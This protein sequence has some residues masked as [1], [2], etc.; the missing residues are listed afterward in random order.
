M[1]IFKDK[2]VAVLGLSVEGLDTMAYFHAKGAR[3]WCCDR[4][5][6]EELGDTYTKLKGIAAGFQ[7]GEN[8][9]AH[10]ER[11]DFIVRTP[12]MSLRLPELAALNKKGKEITSATK[13]FFIEC[14]A[15]IIGVTGT[16]GK[17]TTSTLISEML[18]AGGMHAWLG[19]NVG[20]PLLSK[21][22]AMK[23]TDVVV[24]ELSS[25]QLEDAKESPHIAVVLRT[26]QD[27]LANQDRLAANF[28]E[29]RESYVEAKKSIV[30]YQTD[31]DITILNADDPTSRSFAGATGA[32]VMYFSRT[33]ATD[34]YVRDHTVYLS[35]H[36]TPVRIASLSEIKLRGEHNL[37]NIAAASLAAWA[38]GVSVSAIRK[39]ALSFEGLPHRLETVR[40]VRKVLYVN[41]SFS[42][43]PE[44]AIAALESFEEPVIL[45]AGG[46]EKGSD[47]T[48]LG[49]V[50][51][52]RHVKA[53][54]AIGLMTDRIVTAAKNAGYKGQIITGCTNMKEIV[55]RAAA[56]ARA[57]D[58]VL[59]SPACASFDM[60]HNYKERGKQFKHE[61]SL[62]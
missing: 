58:V 3:I 42:T 31:D 53:L 11:F 57:R 35:D 36:D 27:H 47:F 6:K 12:G 17:G 37:D 33:D 18:T 32:R 60:F 39:A 23:P 30:R 4:R 8:Y 5:T 52:T 14:P 41:D 56:V 20:V 51:A 1:H 7:L 29:S 38:A 24:L 54:I 15:P 43:V 2:T 34:A 55:K 44:T 25:F 16:K 45:I 21:V 28:H 26:T 62:L 59:M 22:D 9:L 13:L 46:S 10:L 19:G 40:T 49:K 50:I 61:V 48:Q